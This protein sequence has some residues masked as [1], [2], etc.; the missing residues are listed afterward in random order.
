MTANT[1][2]PIYEMSVNLRVGWQA[3]SLSNAGSNGSNRLFPRRQLLADGTE[4]D[5]Y[6]GSIAK[7]YH[8]DLTAQYMEEAGVPLCPACTSRDTRRAAALTEHPDYK[9]GLTMARILQGCGICDAHG[10]LVTA[11]KANHDGST[12]ARQK[13]SKSTLIGF[14]FGLALPGQ[15]SDS[16]QLFTRQGDSKEEG[17][18]LMK[19]TA[20]SGQY[21]LGVRYTSVGVGMDT[22][23]WIVVVESEI[24]RRR[25]HRAILLALRDEILSPSGALTATMLPHLTSVVGAIVVRKTTGRAPMYSGLQDDFI[26]RLMKMSDESMQVIPFHSVD[27]F[28]T[29]MNQLVT[30]SVPYLITRNRSAPA[31]SKQST[32]TPTN[33]TKRG[34]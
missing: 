31:A 32:S 18:M 5:A 9:Q 19:M 6:A 20:R 21:S 16:V 27:D 2:V 14:S 4:T 34:N 7:H 30:S 33:R 22:D 8:A 15:H 11:K 28:Y 29:A 23:K 12:T 24:E 17:Q 3:H 25:R 26:D 10:F 13:L 1:T